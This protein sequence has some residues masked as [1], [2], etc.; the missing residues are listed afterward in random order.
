MCTYSHNHILLYT[1]T[2]KEIKYIPDRQK[3]KRRLVLYCFLNRIF[4]NNN[5][6]N[7]KPKTKIR[8]CILK[9][10]SQAK[11]ISKPLKPKRKEEIVFPLISD[12][13]LEKSKLFFFVLLA[14]DKLPIFDPFNKV[15]CKHV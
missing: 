11:Y 7:I 5:E 1:K 13:L 4:S 15:V 6:I 10:S 8:H 2:N 12:S 14:I 9:H 3:T